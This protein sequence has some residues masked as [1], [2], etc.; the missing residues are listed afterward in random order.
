MLASQAFQLS[1]Q[2]IVGIS[3]IGM[4]YCGVPELCVTEIGRLADEHGLAAELDL[5]CGP[6]DFAVWWF[7]DFVGFT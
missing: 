4:W 1:V 2:K 7:N 6:W 5:V 3:T